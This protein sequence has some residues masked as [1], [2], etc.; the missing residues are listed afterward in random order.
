MR[1]SISG[2]QTLKLFLFTT[3]KCKILILHFLKAQSLLYSITNSIHSVADIEKQDIVGSF[4]DI[5]F[6]MFNTQFRPNIPSDTKSLFS[7]YQHLDGFI[8]SQ[9]TGTKHLPQFSNKCM[10]AQLIFKVKREFIDNLI[11]ILHFMEEE[12]KFQRDK[13]SFLISKVSHWQPMQ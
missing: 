6:C 10:M 4:C 9:E 5:E 8:M 11:L 1:N 7:N 13:V 12:A 2:L 3:Q